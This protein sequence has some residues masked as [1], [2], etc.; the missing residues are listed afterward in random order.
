M[1]ANVS[2]KSLWPSNEADIEILSRVL[3]E[4]VECL[5]K[6]VLKIIGIIILLSP[7]PD[8]ILQVHKA[9]CILQR[10]IDSMWQKSM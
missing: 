6:E 7:N 8:Y 3:H 5:Q 4:P 1:S 2:S 10:E 9:E